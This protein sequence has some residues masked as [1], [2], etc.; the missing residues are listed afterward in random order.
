MNAR[1]LFRRRKEQGF[2]LLEVL[3]AFAI[4]A[5]S[6][7]L[8]LRLFSG[9]SAV[10]S[11][12]DDYT[13]AILIGE[14]LLEEIGS[15]A[16]IQPGVREGH[17]SNRYRWTLSITPYPISPSLLQSGM[18]AAPSPYWVIAEVQWGEG[19]NQ[20]SFSLKSLRLKGQ[21]ERQ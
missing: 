10:I 13:N 2:S 1:G 8:L 14:S 7:T 12:T 20:R 21:T 16:T 17:V 15:S 19:V 11:I 18:N 9:S 3:I 6:V 4:M 5:I